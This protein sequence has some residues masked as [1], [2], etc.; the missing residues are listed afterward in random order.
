M[1]IVSLHTYQNE[2]YQIVLQGV[3]EGTTPLVDAVRCTVLYRSPAGLWEYSFI[4]NRDFTREPFFKDLAC[5]DTKTKFE[6]K[7]GK[8]KVL[9]DGKPLTESKG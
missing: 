5:S 3:P 4:T 2:Q 8:D 7:E 6:A 1:A 9:N